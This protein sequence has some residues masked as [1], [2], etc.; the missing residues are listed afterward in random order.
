[1]YLHAKVRV[2]MVNECASRAV[3]DAEIGGIVGKGC[4]EQTLARWLPVDQRG[5]P[6]PGTT[7]PPHDEEGAV[8]RREDRAFLVVS[9]NG[10]ELATPAI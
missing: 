7:T 10:H 6:S 8:L 2:V 5:E 1:M 9:S 4:G 3:V